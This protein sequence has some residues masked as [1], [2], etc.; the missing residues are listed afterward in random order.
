MPT[1]HTLSILEKPSPYFSPKKSI[2]PKFIIIHCTGHNDPWQVLYDNQVSCHYLI[3]RQNETSPVLTAFEVVKPPRRAWHAGISQWKSYK[4]L[5]DWAI[6]IEL[7]LPNYAHAL[8]PNRSLD[9]FYFEEYQ[10][11]IIIALKLLVA[12]I[13]QT[14]DIP[15][16]NIIGHSDVAPWRS[17]GNNT[18]RSKTDPGPTF[19]WKYLAKSKIGIWPGHQH[20]PSS[21]RNNLSALQVQK[22]LRQVGYNVPPSEIF[23]E[24]TNNSI[25]AARMHWTPGCFNQSSGSA[26]DCYDKPIDPE[27]VCALYKVSNRNTAQP[28]SNFLP[29][30]LIGSS[31]GLLLILVLVLW[32]Y[33]RF[34]INN[35]PISYPIS[36]IVDSKLTSQPLDEEDDD[37]MPLMADDS[38]QM[39][40]P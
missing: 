29:Y 19:P 4:N 8:E 24:A 11:K 36:A 32:L 2:T 13:R 12:R 31:G 30:A 17:V 27:L 33:R 34:A 40:H 25:G 5:N 26:R 21:I 38:H 3:T 7:N 10:P 1:K 35:Q 18:I 28:T 20:C 6:G 9:F 22:L 23:D 14:Y 15:D 16:E 37:K 39:A